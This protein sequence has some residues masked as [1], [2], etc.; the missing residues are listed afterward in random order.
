VVRDSYGIAR[1][2]SRRLR[3]FPTIAHVARFIMESGG[4]ESVATAVASEPLAATTVEPSPAVT[5]ADLSAADGV[6][7]RVPVLVPRS[8]LDLCA[9]TGISL[10]EG[11]RVLLVADSGG[12]ATVLADRLRSLGATPIVLD[13]GDTTA[14]EAAL[15]DAIAGGAIQ[16]VFWLPALD[17]EPALQDLD[18]AAW[19]AAL[20]R[21]VKLL[22]TT[23]RTL[24][25]VGATGTFLISASRLGG[26]HGYDTA[27][28]TAPMGGAVTGFTKA[29][30]RERP[31]AIVK[32][33]DNSTDASDALIA[34][35]L[36]AEALKDPG[37]VEVGHALGA[38]WTVRLEERPATDGRAGIAL[39][40][41]TVIAITG[42]AGGIVSAITADLAAASGA[43]FHLL[44]LTPRPDP[45]DPDVA[46]FAND[47]EALKLDLVARMR[48]AGEKVTP[49][50]IEKR[51]AALERQ[52]AAL[53]AIQAVEAA[54]GRAFYHSVDLTDAAAVTAVVDDIRQES[55]TID[56]LI[57]AAGIEISHLLADKEPREFDLVFDVKAD[58]LFNLLR[59]AGDLPS[60]ALV[61]FSSVAGRFGNGGQTDYSAAN[62]L[63]CKMCSSFRSGRPSLRAIAVDW[64]A[65]DRIGMATRGSIPK[66][67][68]MAGIDMLAP[69]VGV[70]TVRR[71]LTAG[72]TRGEV[73]V[74]GALGVL[75]DERAPDGGD[76]QVIA[77]SGYGP[78][79]ER[80]LTTTTTGRLVVET[81]L[82]PDRD[83]FLDHH[84]VEGVALLPGVMGVDAFA[85]AARIACP[86]WYVTAVE[87]VDFTAPFKFYRNEPRVVRVEVDY[88]TDGD[89]VVAECA[90]V[91]SRMLAGRSEP[92]VTVHFTGRVRL[93]ATPP[94]PGTAV[95]PQGPPDTAI[96][97]GD[98]YKV[99]FHGPAY[100]VVD[101]AWAD[102]GSVVGR[103]PANLPTDVRDG[104]SATVNAPRFAELCFQT[105]GVAELGTTGVLAFPAHVD[106]IAVL[107]AAPEPADG[108]LAVVQRNA[109]DGVVDAEVVDASG[110]VFLRMR[111]YRTTPAPL[112]VPDA[113]L[114]P[115]RR[116]LT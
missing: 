60:K 72:G 87:D 74:A 27:G 50:V 32:A 33:V 76:Q 58:G 43:T 57:H 71:E 56:V 77:V 112:T 35:H 18:L 95:R 14:F 40:T 22:Y 67:M 94:T 16:G 47:R 99:Y 20:Q 26:R 34:D 97:A 93:S 61:V 109:E 52:A 73:V 12:V 66:M 84:R 115:F 104:S 69:E 4:R 17:V 8:P 53:S 7:R 65:W 41:D 108:V 75:G 86:G 116:A 98:I 80:V 64:T 24:D 44:D 2:D 82:D 113:L 9:D 29:F 46:L 88:R 63:L 37:A 21:R 79:V 111:G 81:T 3:D 39:G 10:G 103:M 92:V 11:T 114:E 102:G 62:D 85:E 30:A 51:L 54:G 23:M 89:D 83:P 19:R 110:T 1:D 49:V 25:G 15:H 78:M 5:A 106:S 31:E 59:A 91:G 68:E 90:L 42:A 100:Q 36:V 38:R 45:S 70:P 105:G 48:A 28:A 6:P 96:L 55:G 107:A 101:A 13:P